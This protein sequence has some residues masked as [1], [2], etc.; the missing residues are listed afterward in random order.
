MTSPQSNFHHLDKTNKTAISLIAVASVLIL[1]FLFWLIY[2]KEAAESAHTF[3]SH[4]PAINALLNS[5]TTCFLLL[6]FY[7]IRKKM[8]QAHIQTM[9][10]AVVTS[11]A[12]L[13]SYI[14]YHHFHGD[15]QFIAQGFIRPVYF[16]IL[17]SHVIL[18]MAMVPMVFTTL[19][20]AATK[21]WLRHKSLARWTF[22]IWLYVSVT[23]V[24]IFFFLRF[25]NH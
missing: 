24:M 3:T 19:F 21:Q 12:F 18:S 7:F 9:L 5:V 4:L 14:V 10:A 22:P 23:G 13:I 6:G 25:F 20:F 16:F 11:G 17:I 15:T 1:A 2:F 8:I